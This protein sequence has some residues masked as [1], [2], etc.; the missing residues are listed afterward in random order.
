MVFDEI[1]CTSQLSPARCRCI[2]PCKA[3][4]HNGLM[5]ATPHSTPSHAALD[6]AVHDSALPD[7]V[8]AQWFGSARPDAATALAQQKQWFTKSPAFDEQLRERFGVAVQAGMGGALAHWCDQGA[9]G[10]LALIVLLDQFTRNI[11]RGTPHSFAGDPQAL[12][13]ALRAQSEGWD[14]E[15]PEVTR[16][17]MYLPLEHAE[18]LD[19][20]QRSVDAF[21]SLLQTAPDASTQA[22]F[23]GTLDY[24]YKHQDV[25][26]RFGRFPHR[27]PILG[28]SSTPEELD[29]LA[30]PGAGF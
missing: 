13:L 3:V 21:H 15:L 1:F 26:E 6:A 27:N 20:Q 23:S 12:A 17:F 30:Q 18:D 10:R 25:I 16:I 5:Q 7:A 24:A 14:L 29:Y 4:R 28:R 11:Y 19:M 8:L 22:F 2:Y 9:W